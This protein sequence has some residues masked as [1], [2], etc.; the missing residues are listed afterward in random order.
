MFISAQSVRPRVDVF[1]SF[2]EFVSCYRCSAL[3]VFA[4][5]AHFS[6]QLLLFNFFIHSFSHFTRSKHLSVWRPCAC[7]CVC[8]RWPSA[9]CP[10]VLFASVSA[11]LWCQCT[12]KLCRSTN[13]GTVQAD[14]V[15]AACKNN[16]QLGGGGGN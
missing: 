14:E 13:S 15:H 6:P 1:L 11:W 7:V 2:A 10:S 9:I 4:N 12:A 16:L 5:T 3:L 8:N